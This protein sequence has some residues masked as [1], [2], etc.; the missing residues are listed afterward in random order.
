MYVHAHV[1]VRVSHVHVEEILNKMHFLNTGILSVGTDRVIECGSREQTN[2]G[3]YQSDA[4]V[5]ENF[6]YPTGVLIMS[7]DVL[8]RLYVPYMPCVKFILVNT[9]L[10]FQ[11]NLPVRCNKRV[12]SR[13]GRRTPFRVRTAAGRVLQRFCGR[14]SRQLRLWSQ[15]LRDERTRSEQAVITGLH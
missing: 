13:R 11:N 14:P 15:T 12:G 1:H 5:F 9:L 7:G 3:I 10:C 4:T 6:Q 2:W 8:D